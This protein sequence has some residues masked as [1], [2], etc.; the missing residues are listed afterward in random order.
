MLLGPP[1]CF[2]GPRMVSEP[3]ISNHGLE[4]HSWKKRES[5]PFARD[6]MTPL[7]GA[8]DLL[9]YVHMYTKQSG[10]KKEKK[11]GEGDDEEEAR[12]L[13]PPHLVFIYRWSS[14]CVSTTSVLHPLGFSS[15]FALLQVEWFLGGRFGCLSA[16]RKARLI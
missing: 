2:S 16:D 3:V 1:P 5:G 12:F 9:M 7:S 8:S 6:R 13:S 15:I 4:S 10:K 11:K 14:G